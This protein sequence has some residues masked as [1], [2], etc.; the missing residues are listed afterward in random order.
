MQAGDYTS[1]HISDAIPPRWS[2]EPYR[3]LHDTRWRGLGPG[4]KPREARTEALGVAFGGTPMHLQRRSSARLRLAVGPPMLMG[5]STAPLAHANGR[6][7]FALSAHA[8]DL[9]RHAD[10]ASLASASGF[11]SGPWTAEL[12][13]AMQSSA[14]DTSDSVTCRSR[15]HRM[16]SVRTH[17]CWRA[18][19]LAHDKR[20]FFP[21]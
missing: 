8:R 13:V 9:K 14:M 20:G 1:Q 3:P 2:Q 5:F 10:R 11:W 17:G 12:V 18:E 7:L 15:L 21:E 6:A 4:L 16:R 19:S